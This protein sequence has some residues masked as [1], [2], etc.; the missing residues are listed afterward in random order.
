MTQ[1]AVVLKEYFG[2]DQFRPLQKD[3]IRSIL[4]KNDTLVLMP[5]GG[6]KSICFQVP[7]LLF[8]GMT[9]VVS[10][11]ISLM[12][13][14]VDALRANGI[15]AEFLNSSLSGEEEEIIVNKCL[16]SEIKL[17]YVSPERLLSSL[18]ILAEFNIQLFA[19]DE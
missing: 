7:A 6:G 2:Y 3:I 10:P 12:K 4:D 16:R 9:V 13:D 15:E 14:Q 11:L 8:E 19:I 1:A 5:T 17:L 18:S